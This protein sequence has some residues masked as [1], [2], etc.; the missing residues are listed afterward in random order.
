[1]NPLDSERP[2]PVRL[3]GLDLDGALGA[4][5]APFP[6]GRTWIE[7]RRTAQV[8]GVSER[9]VGPGGLSSGD[10]AELDQEF[11][12]VE[13]ADLT[14]VPDEALPAISVVIP[15]L[16]RRVDLLDRAVR[17]VASCGYP[18]FEVIVVD[19]RRR[20][21]DPIPPF[22]GLENVRVEVE[23]FPGASAARNRGAAASSGEVIAFTDDDVE[24]DPRWLRALGVAFATD[25]DLDAVGGMVRP[26]ELDTEAQLW[27]EE[28]FGGFTKTFTP[29]RWSV[30][31]VGKTDPLFP[32]AAGRFG[33]GNNMAVRRAALQRAGGFDVRLGAGTIAR[34]AED[35]KVFIEVLLFGG[36]VAFVPS[37]LVRHSH[38][39]T[40]HEFRE[41]V[42]GYGV[43]L[44]AL[45]CALVAEDPRHLGRILR[46]L[47]R[48]LKMFFRPS[49]P[50]SLSASPSYPRTTAL[51]HAMGMAYGPLA[52]ARSVIAVRRVRRADPPRF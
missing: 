41:Q 51:V 11:R 29:Q 47:P 9:D 48:G 10:L 28:F 22:E 14:T 7:V 37:A 12:D 35:L 38:R 32:Y 42:F 27:F 8:V 5:P 52:Y 18:T 33:A 39:R 20:D 40:P 13:V 4:H 46:R 3:V 25:A 15:T 36:T 2:S 31:L 21:G 26:A 44:T 19:N 49:T 17:S 45:Y 16:Y 50:R 24:V 30:A 34:G 6:V 43:G 23:R 1:M